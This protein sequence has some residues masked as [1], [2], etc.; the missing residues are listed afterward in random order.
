MSEQPEPHEEYQ[1]YLRS[2]RLTIDR[3][4]TETTFGIDIGISDIYDHHTTLS[5]EPDEL[6][7]V[8]AALQQALKDA[9]AYGNE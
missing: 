2:N 5:Y 1:I 6:E 7:A 8:I 9:R 3:Q 4:E